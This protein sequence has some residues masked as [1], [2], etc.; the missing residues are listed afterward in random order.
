MNR[1]PLGFTVVELLIVIIVLSLVAS[2]AIPP[3]LRGRR[4]SKVEQCARHLQ[5]LWGA[6]EDYRKAHKNPPKEIGAAFWLALSKPPAP[7]LAPDAEAF[8]CP[9]AGGSHRPGSTS[10]RGPATDAARLGRNDMLGAD[11]PD[12]HGPGQG[13]HILSVD[14]VVRPF[15]GKDPA[16]IAALTLTSP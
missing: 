1:R 12:N 14:G 5:A 8:F 13:G 11:F 9:L 16:W 3:I 2:L 15:L 6:Q 4:T 7:L 10:Y